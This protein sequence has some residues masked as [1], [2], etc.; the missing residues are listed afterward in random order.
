MSV[1]KHQNWM[2]ALILYV[3]ESKLQ[4]GN[5]G[6][7]RY[8]NIRWLDPVP[9]VIPTMSVAWFARP[10]YRFFSILREGRKREGKVRLTA[11][12]RK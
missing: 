5:S 6:A 4:S 11:D 3:K 1:R 9:R 7:S 12:V 10:A 8:F 2:I